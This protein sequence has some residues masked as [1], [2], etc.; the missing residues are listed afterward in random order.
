M[1]TKSELEDIYNR[2]R[3]SIGRVARAEA[4]RDYRNAVQFAE[5][6]LPLVHPAVTYQRR[7]LKSDHPTAPTV[8]SLLRYAPPLFLRGS[9]DAV[10]KWYSSGTRTERNSLPDVMERV[11]IARFFLRRATELW[12]ILVAGPMSTLGSEGLTLAESELVAVWVSAGF[13]RRKELASRVDFIRT[14]DP[15][16]PMRGKCT[17]CGASQ[18]ATLPQLLDP[19]PC[20]ACRRPC[21]FV[22]TSRAN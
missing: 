19:F 15:R 20:P 7:F 17:R 6:S 22:I 21:Q 4:D 18:E 13:V 10:E 11:E 14:S 3:E 5:A 16:R 12:S 1:A 9:L 8:D 2:Y